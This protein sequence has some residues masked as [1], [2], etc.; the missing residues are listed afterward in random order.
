MPS[1]LLIAYRKFFPGLDSFAPFFR[2]SDPRGLLSPAFCCF[3]YRGIYTP[4]YRPQILT[5]IIH[6]FPLSS[7]SPPSHLIQPC[8]PLSPFPSTRTR[9]HPHP[10]IMSSA[11]VGPWQAGAEC[12]FMMAFGGAL[13]VGNMCPPDWLC[14]WGVQCHKTANAKRSDLVA[15][16]GHA[17]RGWG[18]G[19]L[20]VFLIVGCWFSAVFLPP[21]C[22]L[23]G[24]LL[25]AFTHP[26]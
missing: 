18:I 14:K 22:S 4:E 13:G 6:C 26:V 2:R 16:N 19:L 11:V 15:R 7:S 8:H 9:P 24:F 1:L 25:P 17:A 12:A 20:V 5:E 3:E 23:P 21:D 10:S